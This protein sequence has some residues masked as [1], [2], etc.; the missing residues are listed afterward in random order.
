MDKR[1]LIIVPT[2]S[3]VE[4]MASDF[5]DYGWSAK[6][7][8]KIYSGHDRETH[9]PVV[10]S[11]WQSLYKLP[12]KFFKDYGVVFGDEAHLFKAKSLTN[13]MEKLTDCPYRFGFTGTLDGT[14]TH[15][16]VLEGLFG[17]AEKVITTKELM[18]SDTLA[19]LNVVCLLLK[20]KEEESKSIKDSNYAD[21]IQYLISHDRRNKFLFNLCDTL[22]GN[23]LL[24]YQ[25]VE[26]HGM[27]LY[28]LCQK[29]DRDLHFVYGGVDAHERE[30][31]RRL[32]EKSNK[33]LI[34]AS[35]GTFSTGINIK[36]INN[37]IFASPSKSRIR[38]LQSIGR[39]LRK[40][41]TKND[42]TLYDISDDLS[43]KNKK[44]FT[45]RHFEERIN[46]YNEEE[47][48]YRIDKVNL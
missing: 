20:H 10:I 17:K 2:T 6:Q 40:S 42:V 24:L 13:I 32:T 48:D 19:K 25:M 4:Q 9:K 28:K 34:I 15:R 31:V 30:K 5:V 3:L 29:L 43:Y 21:E 35:Y 7:I 8:H 38:V 12:K 16:L 23:T 36:N 45:L 26:K 27:V 37:V 47:F 18:D 11:T 39:G 1:I 22:K 14:Q 33:S 41:E 46:I 44:N